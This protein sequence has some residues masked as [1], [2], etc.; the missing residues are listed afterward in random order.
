MI[1]PEEQWKVWQ[2]EQPAGADVSYQAYL[3]WCRRQEF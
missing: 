2:S 1:G 3:T